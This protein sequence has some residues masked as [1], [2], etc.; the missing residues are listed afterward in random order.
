[1]HILKQQS[2][3]GRRL[4][5]GKREG[6]KKKKKQLGKKLLSDKHLST[7]ANLY[8]SLKEKVPERRSLS[9]H[10]AAALCWELR[11][12]PAHEA[13]LRA[14]ARLQPGGLKSSL[15]FGAQS[16]PFL[17]RLFAQSGFRRS[18][19]ICPRPPPQDSPRKEKKDQSACPSM[20]SRVGPVSQHV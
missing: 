14:A 15:A 5:R 7:R 11:G 17:F 10:E 19:Q 9:L 3:L 16:Q 12:S 6:E 20:V 8:G 1:M 18:E 13:P 2:G 4:R